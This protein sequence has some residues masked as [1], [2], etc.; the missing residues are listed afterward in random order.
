MQSVWLLLN[1]PANQVL[2]HPLLALQQLEQAQGH[3]D[4]GT[5]SGGPALLQAEGQRQHYTLLHYGCMSEADTVSAPSRFSD[6]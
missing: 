3:G 6:G 2:E 4:I 1:N 5:G